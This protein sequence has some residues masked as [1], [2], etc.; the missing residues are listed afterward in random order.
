[1]TEIPRT[2]HQIIASLGEISGDYDVALCDIW[3]VLHDGRKAFDPAAQALARFRQGGGT[4]ILITNAPRPSADIRSQLSHFSIPDEAY[5]AI[6]TSGDITIALIRAHGAAPVYH[7]GPARDLGLFELAA[8]GETEP[9]LTPLE[10]AEYVVCTGL[11][12]DA[13]ETPADYEDSLRA[14]AARNLPM[15]CANP[16]LVVHRGADL[17]YCAGA[18]AQRYEAIGGSAIYAGKPHAPIYDAAL[19]RAASLRGKPVAK[20]RVL[21]IGDAMHT[22]IAGAAAQG[23]DALFITSGIHRDDLHRPG[24]ALGDAIEMFSARHGLRPR[25]F[26]PSLEP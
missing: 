8:Q 10:Q 6:V 5:D 21:A 11:F 25:A 16:D 1:M 13:V 26:A 9:V 18:L 24:E 17:I 2:P 4:V 3:G 12:H 15:I 20:S 22:D 23:L 14:M 19:A 7:L